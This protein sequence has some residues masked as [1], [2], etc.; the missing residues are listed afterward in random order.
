[1]SAAVRRVRVHPGP[2]SGRLGVP[3]DKSVSHRVV[4]MGALADGGATV[5]GVVASGDVLATIAAVRCMGGQ[6]WLDPAADGLLEGR[7]EGPLGE[8]CDVVDCGNSGTGLRLLAG[9]AAG[10]DA[11]TVL[12]GDVSLRG[13][14]MARIV[15][16]LRA[17]GAIV[18]GRDGGRLPPLVVRGGKLHPLTWDSPVASAQVKSCLLL[19][20]LVGRVDVTVSSRLPSRDHTERLLRAGGID[21]TT[22]TIDGR[23]IVALHPG[24]LRFDT[25]LRVPGDPSSAAF[26]LVAGA[27]G[28]RAVTVTDVSVN[29]TR[30]GAIEVLTDLGAAV[31][32]TGEAVRSGEPVADVTIRAGAQL[33][34]AQ[35]GGRRVVDAID[36]L[37]VLALAGAL[38]SGGL[39]VSDATELRAKESD[40]IVAMARTFSALGMRLEER[41][42][43]YL[44][45]G[46][47]RPGPGIVDAGG[48]H[49][50]AMTACVA[51]T[52]ASGPV[53][54]TGFDCVATSY[55]TFL[56]DLA[57][58][59]GRVE[60]LEEG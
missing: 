53:E 20:G 4:L 7:V 38:S 15:D 28:G 36:E 19:A 52:V 47:Q 26:W 33:A 30:T 50:I 51:A 57:R 55:P 8:A 13:R 29:P 43:G 32:S 18:D 25:T 59:G 6:V 42:D 58:L 46:G 27:I 21:V 14:P 35:V 41:P 10:M 40:R 9:L 45:P 5:S 48:D 3:G 56:D 23:E 24:T 16:P 54:V 2:L 22:A 39:D 37:P 44:V 1:V 17:M 31:D 49:R 34:S 11:V 60:V 12:T